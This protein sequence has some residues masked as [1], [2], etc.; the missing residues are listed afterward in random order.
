MPSKFVRLDM[1]VVGLLGYLFQ[2]CSGR[3]LEFKECVQCQMYKT[4][5]LTEDECANCTFVPSG[6]EQVEGIYTRNRS[7]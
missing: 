2:T 3:C 4:G 1:N 6:H 7:V 5:P